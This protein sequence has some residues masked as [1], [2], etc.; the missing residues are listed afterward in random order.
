VRKVTAGLGTV[1][2][3]GLLWFAST[4]VV[5]VGTFVA[6][7][8]A[9]LASIY[10]VRSRRRRASARG[11]G[12]GPAWVASTSELGDIVA[13][14]ELNSRLAERFG[15]TADRDASVHI[16]RTA[17]SPGQGAALLN[18]VDLETPDGSAV[19]LVE[20]VVGN[21][22]SELLLWRGTADAGLVLHTETYDVLEPL[23]QVA[24]GPVSVLYFPYLADL[25]RPRRV[26]RPEFR[27]N[28]HA[29]VWAVAELNGRNLLGSHPRLSDQPFTAT[30]PTVAALKVRL[31]VRGGT[32]KALQRSWDAA[33][34][35]WLRL[36]VTYEQLPRC[37]YHND[38][39]PWNVVCRDGRATTFAD[40]G[41][42]GAGPV[43]SDL[44]SVI[45][46][47]GKYIHDAAYIDDMLATYFEALRPYVSTV[48]LA[49]IRLAAWA[50][51]FL[52][53]TDLRFGSARGTCTAM[54]WQ[55]GACASCDGRSGVPLGRTQDEHR[56]NGGF[57]ML[58]H[59]A[60]ACS[61]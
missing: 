48:G 6:A 31:G 35:D 38:V 13:D 58:V 24:G 21:E 33:H 1:A 43:G 20:K 4:S 32:A 9:F 59:A 51:F 18:R 23:H 56:A 15:H 37:L 14:L 53:Y 5:L 39:T 8:V 45:R 3:A 42:S 7:A 55:S 11:G 57:S 44:H 26:L 2:A 54:S 46:W 61:R 36:H 60:L 30:R 19:T 49:D 34:D 17:M 22:G 52:R 27:K 25:D 16:V 12:P 40:L 41:L 50:T 47:S 28:M 29:I 10:L